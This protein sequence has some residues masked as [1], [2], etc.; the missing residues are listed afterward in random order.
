MTWRSAGMS[1]QSVN[2]QAA[3]DTSRRVL[4]AHDAIGEYMRRL[5][6]QGIALVLCEAT[7]PG[8]I[9]SYRAPETAP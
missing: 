5:H 8:W 7:G 3:L 4:V 6:A 1:P 2:D 9:V